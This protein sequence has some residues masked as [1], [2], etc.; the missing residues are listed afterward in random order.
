MIQYHYQTEFKIEAE[1]QYTNWIN[2]V[3]S[4]R[5]VRIDHLNYI[6]TT[7][8]D[9]LEINRKHLDHDYYTDII[10]FPYR[11][12]QDISGDIY[13]SIERVEDNAKTLGLTF[14][15]ELRRVMIHG[16]LHLLGHKDK[17]DKETMEM[18]KMEDKA[19][20]MFHVEQ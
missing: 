14:E 8:P 3:V 10:T 2:D 1:Q 16:V 5:N 20:R 7:D 17:T 15:E 4:A 6:F 11:E 18:R 9:L 12:F 13:I 19:L